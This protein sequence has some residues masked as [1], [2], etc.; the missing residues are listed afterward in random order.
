M[1]LSTS[2]KAAAVLEEVRKVFMQPAPRTVPAAMRR[3]AGNR[4][5][6]S[7][8]LLTGFFL[9]LQIPGTLLMVWI[10]KRAIHFGWEQTPV[11]LVFAALIAAL[12]WAVS[13]YRKPPVILAT[14]D[15]RRGRIVGIRSLPLRM[16]S[17][18]YFAVKAEF[19]D[20]NGSPRKVWDAVENTASEYFYQA[21]ANDEEV[22][23]IFSPKASKHCVLVMKMAYQ[24]IV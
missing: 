4:F 18:S 21:L 8:M 10:A 1:N 11:F 3:S 14:G 2:N 15:I 23:L 13:L 22:E 9:F 12:G 20:E 24:N 16:F 17:T 7:L 19:T 5:A 6:K